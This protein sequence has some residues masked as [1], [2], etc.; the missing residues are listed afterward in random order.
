[1][2]RPRN[3]V[4]KLLVD[5][6]NPES[7]ARAI[8]ALRKMQQGVAR[9]DDTLTAVAELIEALFI[10]DLLAQLRNYPPRKKGMKMR[11][12]SRKQQRYVMALLRRQFEERNGHPPGP[13]DDISYVRTGALGEAWQADVVVT[14]EG[15]RVRVY[16][17]AKNEHGD[18]I[19]P[20]VQGS[21]GL[22]ESRQSSSRYMRPMQGFHQD[23]GWAPAYPTIQRYVKQMVQV[24][25][26]E[27][28]RAIAQIEKDA[29]RA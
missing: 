29:T 18:L 20:F 11:W 6:N 24:A 21:I 13:G 27:F 12:T 22:G 26:D 15:L 16:N 17:T 2:A 4:S 7:L 3:T 23:R 10:N 19:A 25:E 1:M 28:A 9:L 5:I 14:R 8:K